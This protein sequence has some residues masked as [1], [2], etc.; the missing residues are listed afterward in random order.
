MLDI[1][2]DIYRNK[3]ILYLYLPE[4]TVEYKQKKW[5]D[6]EFIIKDFKAENWVYNQFHQSM[7]L[8]LWYIFPVSLWFSYSNMINKRKNC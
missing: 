3:I 7:W 6:P 1:S 4:N 8:S 2:L 5:A